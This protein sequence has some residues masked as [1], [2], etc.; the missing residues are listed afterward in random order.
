MLLI[1]V[2]TGII[3]IIA[4]VKYFQLCKYVTEIRNDVEYYMNLNYPKDKTDKT[5]KTDET[6]EEME[7]G[8]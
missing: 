3:A 5:D 4:L 1:Q 8:I 7:K 2:V 6:D